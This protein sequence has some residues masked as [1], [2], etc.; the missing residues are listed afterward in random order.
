[1]S[2]WPEQAIARETK[3][4]GEIIN[5]VPVKPDKW[6]FE[7]G[8]EYSS[9]LDNTIEF[10]NKYYSIDGMAITRLSPK[11]QD[12]LQR[13]HVIRVV[14]RSTDQVVGTCFSILMSLRINGESVAA[15]YT[16]YLCV[17]PDHTKRGLA[18][19]LIRKIMVEGNL[20][21]MFV[22][23]H[24]SSQKI[25]ENAIPIVGWWYPVNHKLART[26]GFTLPVNGSH[27]KI[28][29]YYQLPSTKG[30]TFEPVRDEY[31]DWLQEQLSLFAVTMN[32]GDFLKF[33]R[34][35]PG[36]ESYV[37]CLAGNL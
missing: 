33:L 8:L 23:Y 13:D 6:Q 24:I 5:S 16:T 9:E 22:G 25:G 3:S 26:L 12:Y 2:F 28:R 36:L 10:I 27:D 31:L 15:G 1:M 20:R 4:E 35:C 37:V 29:E 34:E 21:N 19:S 18:S 14:V 32:F 7:S 17:H 11:F 30:L